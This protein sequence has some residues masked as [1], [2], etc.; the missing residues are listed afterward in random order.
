MRSK[1]SATHLL[2]HLTLFVFIS[3]FLLTMIRAA[4][5]LWQFPSVM[6]TNSLIELFLLGLRF[7]LALVGI[8]LLPALLL[9]CVFGLLDQTKIIAKF[10]VILLL[11]VGMVFIVLSELITPYFMAEQGIRPDSSVLAAITDPVALLKGIWSAYMIPTVIGLILAALIIF[12]YWARLET[13]RMFKFQLAPLSTVVLLV[14]G[15]ALCGLAIYSGFDL[16]K[17]A[18]SPTAALITTEATINEIALN[19]GY[20]ILH[21]VAA[22]FLPSP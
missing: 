21:S 9:G 10:L 4:Y 3:V 12:A 6:Q 11:M 5:V 2:R 16:N 8:I 20:K 7:D 13:N 18:L 19:S 14:I 22:P 15:T 17:P 1:L